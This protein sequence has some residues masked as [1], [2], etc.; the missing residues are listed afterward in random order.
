MQSFTQ[1]AS[2]LAWAPPTPWCACGKRAS[3]RWVNH[4]MPLSYYVEQK[5]LFAGS[6]CFELLLALLGSWL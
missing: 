6:A 3:P 5:A 1:T 4:G 2:F